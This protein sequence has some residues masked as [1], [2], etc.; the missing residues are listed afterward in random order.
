VETEAMPSAL[1]APA[2]LA[3]LLLSVVS[4]GLIRTSKI[5]PPAKKPGAT[6]AG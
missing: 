2:L 1:G 5:S 3:V 6:S 4:A